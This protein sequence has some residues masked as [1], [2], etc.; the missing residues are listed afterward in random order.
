MIGHIVV[1]VYVVSVTTLVA[2]AG[3]TT[4]VKSR[5][6]GLKAFLE[7]LSMCFSTSPVPAV[8]DIG[9]GCQYKRRD[10]NRRHKLVTLHD[11]IS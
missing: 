6:V 10:H 4:K 7:K 11:T 2:S 3:I 1:V 9:D 8:V 5:K